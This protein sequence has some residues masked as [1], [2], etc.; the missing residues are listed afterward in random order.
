MIFPASNDSQLKIKISPENGTPRKQSLQ[1]ISINLKPLKTSNP[2]ALKSCT[3][4]C[5][6][7]SSKMKLSSD[8][9]LISVDIRFFQGEQGIF[10][11]QSFGF[12]G[13]LFSYS[14][15]LLLQ[16]LSLS[17]PAEFWWRE[18]I[19]RSRESFRKMYRP[20]KRRFLL[21]TIIFRG[22]VSFRE[23]NSKSTWKEDEL[24]FWGPACRG[25]TVGF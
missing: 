4:L 22:Y 23:G 16:P 19:G 20:W 15:V 9:H 17:L 10:G 13:A 24:L 2:V 21:E 6:P 8:H 11:V 18:W 3:R 1:L 7:G 14:Q 25:W 12:P 5:F